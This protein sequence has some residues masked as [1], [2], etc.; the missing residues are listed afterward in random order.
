M[1]QSQ[2][3]VTPAFVD[4]LRT[5]LRGEL[6]EREPMTRHTTL[7]IGGPADVWFAPAT[8]ADLQEARRLCHAAGV[9]VMALG[10][11]SNLLVKDGGIRGVCISSRA[12]TGVQRAELDITVE[13]GTKTAMLLKLCT[14]WELGGVE[15][16]GG[17][18]GT[19]G[20]GMIMNAGTYLG[21]LKD[22]TRWVDS[23]TATG[24]LR[25]RSA[26]ECGFEY[27]RSALPQGE[28]VVSAGLHLSPRPRAEITAEV[29]AL[30]ERRR[31]REPK[32]FPN[33]GSIFKNPPGDFAGR[34]I[35]ACGL[36]GRRIGGAEVSPVHANWIVNVGGAAGCRAA[37]VLA[38]VEVVRAEVET[39]FQVRLEMEVKLAGEDTLPPAPSRALPVPEAA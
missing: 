17:V 21:E 31:Q 22:V 32:G 20:G 1:S 24:E 6:R 19:V 37:D 36:K 30:R 28:M 7:R 34:L 27:R 5:R 16:L 15:F 39:R 29:G 38:L 14:D 23:V 2:G 12:L 25:R 9:P 8:I 13:S 4:H 3:P 26:E 33:A 11:G 10:G 18:P 35:E